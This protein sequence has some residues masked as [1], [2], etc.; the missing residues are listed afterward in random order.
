MGGGLSKRKRVAD[1]SP[2]FDVPVVYENV[3]NLQRQMDSYMWRAC[4]P[5]S[6]AEDAIVT[7]RVTA[8][9]RGHVE[10]RAMRRTSR[11]WLVTSREHMELVEL[12]SPP[13]KEHSAAS[14]N[15]TSQAAS[16]THRSVLVCEDAE[17]CPKHPREAVSPGH[18]RALSIGS[19]VVLSPLR[20]T[21]TLD[22][23]CDLGDEATALGGRHRLEGE[24]EVQLV[25]PARIIERAGSDDST[26]GSFSSMH[27]STPLDGC[28][29]SLENA[30]AVLGPGRRGDN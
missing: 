22:R 17:P 10:R 9:R 16:E 18:E 14:V 15:R 28:R 20:A 11:E 7:A 23:C 25:E 30:L 4:T 6:A 24:E 29:S 13:K 12:P 21:I 26:S 3:A 5:T 27:V 1:Y 2:E 19:D 8:S